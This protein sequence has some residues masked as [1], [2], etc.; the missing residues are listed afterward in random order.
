[1]GDWSRG[2]DDDPADYVAPIFGPGGIV[3]APNPPL[4]HCATCCCH[5]AAN[6]VP[7]R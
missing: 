5:R 2:P 3:T 4:A 6:A 7:E 1:M